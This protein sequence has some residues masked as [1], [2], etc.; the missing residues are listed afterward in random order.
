LTHYLA[1]DNQIVNT[2]Y[3]QIR[4]DAPISAASNRYVAITERNS[5][6]RLRIQA[7]DA[8]GG[9]IGTG[10][11]VNPGNYFDTTVPAIPSTGGG[12]QNIGM[13]VYPLTSFLTS[14]SDIYGFRVTQS[15]ASGGDGGDGK[16]FVMFDPAFLTPP[17]TIDVTTSGVQPTCP[18]NEG[19]I[20]ID[21]TDNG[22]GTI[23]YSVNGAA[24]P[25][26]ASNVFNN[27]PPATYTPAVRYQATPTCLAVSINPI[28]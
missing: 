23:E 10:I 21:A 11:E 5:N 22:G 20:T 25:W 2:D 1:A 26:Q 12:A 19:S 24:G 15:G 3:M 14:G 13:A 6:N 18:S 8:S 28:T 9:L 27:L 4:Y 17:P 7:L 16:V